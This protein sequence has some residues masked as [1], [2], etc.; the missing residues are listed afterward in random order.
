MEIQ[1]I[2]ERIW[3]QNRLTAQMEELKKRRK[4]LERSEWELRTAREREQADVDRL[5][6]GSLAKFFY[7][8]MGKGEEK[9]EKEKQEAYAAAV[10]H[11]TV[12][13]ELDAVCQEIRQMEQK[14]ESVIRLEQELERAL[15]EKSRWLKANCPEQAE[16]ILQAEASLAQWNGELKEIR[17][18]EEAGRR[19]E[20]QA[21]AVKKSLDSAESWGTLD[22]LGGG[23]ASTMAKHSRMD[24]AQQ[25]INELQ[26]CLAAFRTELIDVPVCADIQVQTDGFLRFADYFWDGF[27]VDW[28]VQN[29]IRE[30]QDQIS[31]VIAQVRG[32]RMDLQAMEQRLEKQMEEKKQWLEMYIGQA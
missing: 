31:Q 19:A 18:A 5:E 30:A 1:E 25:R 8:I 21:E 23:L 7:A 14:Q 22:L 27:L 4:E 16:T 9:L 20:N 13:S 3:A 12:K 15:E 28:T 24:E 17:E 26:T 29:Q 11:D 2:R 10:K 32:I 6:Q